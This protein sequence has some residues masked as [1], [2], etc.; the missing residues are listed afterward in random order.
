MTVSSVV[1]AYALRSLPYPR[2]VHDWNA[3]GRKQEAFPKLSNHSSLIRLSNYTLASFFL[4]TIPKQYVTRQVQPL[5]P[6]HS[7][8]FT[9]LLRYKLCLILEQ[10]FVGEEPRER[11][12]SQLATRYGL[13]RKTFKATIKREK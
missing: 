6:H 4:P 1:K 11:L 3:P 7:S 13:L 2:A 10:T 9:L 5:L 8:Y 12:Q